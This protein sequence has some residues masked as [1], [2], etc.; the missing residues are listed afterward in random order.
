MD[1]RSPSRA[2]C[3]PLLICAFSPLRPP[4]PRPPLLPGAGEEKGRRTTPCMCRASPPLPGTRRRG[5]AGTTPC[6]RTP[7]HLAVTPSRASLSAAPCRRGASRRPCASPLVSCSGNWRKERGVGGGRRWREEEWV[8]AD[9]GERSG[10]RPSVER[11]GG[12]RLEAG[13]RR[14]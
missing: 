4:D 7:L 9:G 14:E 1:T 12:R 13:E 3:R 5:V 10:W 2:H 6:R 8:E 11:C